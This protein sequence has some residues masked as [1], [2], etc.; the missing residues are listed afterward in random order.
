MTTQGA[1]IT[2]SSAIARFLDQI[3]LARSENTARTYANAL[4]S[5][6]ALL[7]NKKMDPDKTSLDQ[8]NEDAVGWFAA[9]LKEYAP[10][11]EQLYLTALAGFFEYLAAERLAEPNLPRMRLLIRQRAR[12][13]GQR[14]AAIS[15]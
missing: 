15:A 12:K 8:L 6:T 9:Y 13:P 10:A 1:A 2:I 11:T 7:K 14:S 5:F 3:S 4:Q